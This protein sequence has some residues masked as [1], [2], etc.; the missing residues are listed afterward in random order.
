[1]ALP[2]TPLPLFRKDVILK[3]LHRRVCKSCDSKGV[4]GKASEDGASALPGKAA[5]S[6]RTP[7]DRDA[8]KRAPTGENAGTM[9]ST[10]LRP[11]NRAPTKRSERGEG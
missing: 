11:R 4:N 9:P 10:T 1:M 7:K 8:L 5:S 6:R 2:P 3:D